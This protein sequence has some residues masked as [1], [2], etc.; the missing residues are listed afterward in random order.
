MSVII[1]GI[2]MPDN[3]Y[4]CPC[5]Y[6]NSTGN[7]LCR[8]LDVLGIENDI[9][10]PADIKRLD[11]CPM[12][13]VESDLI[14]AKPIAEAVERAEWVIGNLGTKLCECLLEEIKR[15]KIDE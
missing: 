1:K 2:D 3:C 12:E 15:G 5:Y 6:H 13:P 9:P 14:H 4:V 7:S 8:A 10:H 11:N